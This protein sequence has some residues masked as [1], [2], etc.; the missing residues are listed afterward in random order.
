M[1]HP[2]TAHGAYLSG[3]DAANRIVNYIAVRRSRV[4]TLPCRTTVLSYCHVVHSY[5]I[6]VSYLCLLVVLFKY[7]R[8]DVCY[9]DGCVCLSVV[10]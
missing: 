1:P 4:V 9:F 7:V 5:V 2:A 10:V 6:S 8:S 3:I